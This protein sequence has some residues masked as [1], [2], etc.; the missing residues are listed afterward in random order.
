[1]GTLNSPA[2]NAW[3]AVGQVSPA[4]PL[5]AASVP[6][7]T[8]NAMEDQLESAAL[9]LGSLMKTLSEVAFPA[10]RFTPLAIYREIPDR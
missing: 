3:V 10:V 7:P 8:G 9:G 1:M 2:Q 5:V 6:M 4:P